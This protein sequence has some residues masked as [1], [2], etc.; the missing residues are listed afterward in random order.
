MSR[1][2]VKEN[3]NQDQLF[4]PSEADLNALVVAGFTP[5]QAQAMIDVSGSTAAPEA[6][7]AVGFWAYVADLFVRWNTVTADDLVRA[8]FSGVQVEA[9]KK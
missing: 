8:G 1:K 5:V 9:L 7:V 3:P 4:A 2:T 6:M